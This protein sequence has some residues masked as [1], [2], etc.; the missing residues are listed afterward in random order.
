MIQMYKSK[1]K[2]RYVKARHIFGLSPVSRIYGVIAPLL[3]IALFVGSILLEGFT[4][5]HALVILCFSV[6]IL[7]IIK[8]V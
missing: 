3:F 8:Q 4:I 7:Y 5:M 2:D 1:K 6:W